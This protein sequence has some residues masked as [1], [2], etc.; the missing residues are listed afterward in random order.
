MAIVD[1]VIVALAMALGG[2]MLR[3][4]YRDAARDRAELRQE[5]QALAEE[6]RRLSD[7]TFQLRGRVI[8]LES[9]LLTAL[10]QYNQ[11]SGSLNEN[12]AE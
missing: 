2:L 4:A 1:A 10:E 9:Q 11:L 3:W 8:Q 5:R 6:N 7:E 12:E